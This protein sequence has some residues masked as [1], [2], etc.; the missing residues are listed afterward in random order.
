MHAQ[1]SRPLA[2]RLPEDAIKSLDAVAAAS[3]R[4]R[5]W[6]IQ[7]AVRCYLE[8]EGAD[9]LAVAKGRAAVNKGQGSSLDSVIAEVEKI[10]A[11]RRPKAA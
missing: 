3:D 4:S 10:V 2:I 9:M 5:S 11:R 8:T 6:I 7:R 1:S